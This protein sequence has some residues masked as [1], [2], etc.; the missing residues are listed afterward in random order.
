MLKRLMAAVAAAV[1]GLA[2]TVVA[3]QTA[4]ADDSK[5]Y[6]TPGHHLVGG[7]YWQTECEKYSTSV[8]RCRTDIWTSKVVKAGGSY[9]NHKGWVFNNL[10]YLPSDRGQ[11]DANPL[12]KSTT[13]FKDKGGRQWKTE[14]DT[15]ATG[16]HGCRS[17]A[18]ATVVEA[19]GSG[20]KK[21]TKWTFN[22]MVRF[23]NGTTSAVTSIPAS[24]PKLDGVPKETKPV[25][26]GDSGTATDSS[27]AYST[28]KA[29]YY[30]QGQRTANGEYFN[31]NGYTTAHKS[32]RFGTKVKVVNPKNG[33][34]VVVRVNDRGPY[35]SG[36]CL[37]LSRAAMQAIGGTSAGVLTVK[38]Q[39]LG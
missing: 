13:S 7:R 25:V 37:D 20:F 17:Y 1:A 31:P 15:S 10:T 6:T 12:G 2:F 5:V 16:R 23:T 28:C 3:P 9:V 18:K 22:N 4:Q 24:A 34:S 36:R 39:V 35:I 29:S 27:N 30:W 21:S 32:L 14:C 26:P 11:W 8:V 19:S 38:Y 33:K